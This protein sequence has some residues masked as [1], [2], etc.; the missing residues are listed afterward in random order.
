[1]STT[2]AKKPTKR[3]AKAHGRPPLARG[4]GAV[5]GAPNELLE[6]R[7][8]QGGPA[9]SRACPTAEPDPEDAR[10]VATLRVSSDALELARAGARVA[11][12]H[13]ATVHEA[14]ASTTR[15]VEGLKA[16]LEELRRTEA[17]LVEL[18]QARGVLIDRDVALAVAGQLAARFV[19]ALDRFEARLVGQIEAWLGDHNFAPRPT[20]DRARIVREWV[21]V[22][23]HAAR[24]TEATE[25]EQLV[26]AEIADR[27]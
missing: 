20:E 6:H 26:E 21:R 17:G 16:A 14:G 22:Q 5:V 13:L 27:R 9:S 3:G 18:G 24:V 25:L 1:M 7:R 11:G 15:D 2:R 19:G 23:A 8:R 10:L 4:S 12:R